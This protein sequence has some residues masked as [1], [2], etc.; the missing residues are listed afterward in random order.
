VSVN[1]SSVAIAGGGIAGMTTA[2]LLARAGASVTLLER[3]SEPSAVGAGILLQPN[4]LAVLAG[5]GVDQA[6]GR[7]GHR[8]V[9]TA[10]RSA[11]GTRILSTSPP[12]HG[13]WFDGLLGLRRSRLH[14]CLLGA[15][16]DQPGI[17]VRLGATVVAARTAGSVRVHR[18]DGDR[19]IQADLVVGADGV[20]SIVRDCGDFGAQVRASGATYLR[21]LVAGDDL[22]LKDE[23]WTPLGLFGGL[24]MGDG[25][26]YFYA[27]ATA[28]PVAAAVAGGD[29]DALRRC[30]AT[31]LPLAGR[32]LDR[33]GSFEELLVNEVVRV[34]CARWSDGR[35]VLVGD[36]AHAMAPNLG[37]GANSALVDA[38][39]LSTMLAAEQPVGQA[40]ARYAARRR[41]AVGRVQDDADRLARLSSIFSPGLR[42][43]RDTALRL[44]GRPLRWMDTRSHRVL[45]EDP[46]WLYAAVCGLTA[47]R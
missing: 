34:D 46:A 30:W 22:G 8:P 10:I 32:V 17:T 3:V 6:L 31:V 1:G 16:R 37:Q 9:G 4:G 20:G 14:E 43:L 39:V 19:T 5:L 11:D 7:H 26:T 45:Q 12:D 36:A 27:A 24:P 28:P 25:T 29:V 13:R 44:S 21:G 47:Y 23:Y 40:L 33:V 38:A 41:P 18:R 2:L 35:L 15:A 42:R